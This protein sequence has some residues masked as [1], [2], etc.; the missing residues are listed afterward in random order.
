M[1]LGRGSGFAR[2][3]VMIGDPGTP[4]DEA[5][6]AISALITDV[7][8]A[9]D[10][11]DY[12]GRLILRTPIRVTDRANG[13][14]GKEAATVVDTSLGVPIDCQPTASTNLGASCSI[15]T[16]ID[17]LVPGLAQERK[18]TVMSAFQLS[19]ED[20]GADGTID[21]P[22]SGQCP[23]ACGSGDERPFLIQGVFAP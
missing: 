2:L 13:G 17:T 10:G 20:A 8:N 15:S 18:L 12:G 9:S 19:V 21:P 3:D 11:S 6:V 16:T 5:D 7:R 4:E 14:T 1:P 23:L 22:G